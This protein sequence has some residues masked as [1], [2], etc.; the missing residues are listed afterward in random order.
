MKKIY[1][2]FVMGLLTLTQTYS[3]SGSLDATFDTDGKKSFQAFRGSNY[4][5]DMTTQAD[6]KIVLTGDGGMVSRLNTDGS[7][8]TTFDTDGI[9]QI[10]GGTLNTIAIQPDGK[11]LVG[12]YRNNSGV[13]FKYF[14]IYRLNTNGSLD[15]TFDVDGSTQTTFYFQKNSEISDMKLQA[16]G[17]IVAVGYTEYASNQTDDI[18][19]ARFNTDGS[20]DTT[21]DGDGKLTSTIN[22]YDYLQA[23]VIQPDGKIVVVGDVSAGFSRS[24]FVARYNTDGT[25]DTT[26]D[27]D[28]KITPDVSGNSV[29]SGFGVGLLEDVVLQP[30]GKIILAGYGDFNTDIDGVMF[31]LNADGSIDTSFDTDGKLRLTQFG[32]TLADRAYSLALQSDGKIIVAGL[33]LKL[34]GFSMDSDFSLYKL[35]ADGSLDTTFD[36]DG[37]V[38]TD[39]TPNRYDEAYVVCL[40]ADGKILVAG[41]TTDPVTN[42]YVLGV[43]RYNNDVNLLATPSFAI[44]NKFNISPNPANNTFTITQNPENRYSEMKIA[45]LN[46]RIVFENKIDNE[47]QNFDLNLNTGIYLVK[48]TNQ[49]GQFYTKKLIIK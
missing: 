30:D 6:G 41:D 37:K 32:Q 14:V 23:V 3:Q 31:R 16:D 40:Q 5:Y 8:D 27:G 25:P 10:S 28:G 12:G 22:S 15:T 20:L 33:S 43:A 2:I 1:F 35:N 45:D 46:G 17:K 42:N 7:L 36:G 26:F 47:T 34:V 9:V 4:V 44:N 18:A 24:Y 11:I 38:N 29:L 19:I 39:F 49:N 21:F 13:I 48:L